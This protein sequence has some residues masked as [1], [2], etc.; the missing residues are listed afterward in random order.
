VAIG[1]GYTWRLLL[2]LRRGLGLLL[3]RDDVQSWTRG[4]ASCLSGIWWWSEPAID[5]WIVVRI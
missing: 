2:W 1:L 3:W 4:R 5:V